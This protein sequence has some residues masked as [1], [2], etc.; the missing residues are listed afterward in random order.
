MFKGY[1]YRHWI[2]NEEGIEKSY[3]GLTRERPNRRWRNGD[4]YLK[5]GQ[6]NSKFGNAIR[7]YGWDSFKHEIIGVVESDTKEQLVL[8]LNEWEIYYIEK[9]DSF[10]NGYNSTLGGKSIVFS[11]EVRKKIS[12]SQKGK[13]MSEE[14]KKKMSNAKKGKQLNNEHKKKIGDTMRGRK[15]SEESKKKI[16]NGQRTTKVICIT[17]GEV[18]DS[19]GQASRHY[20]VDTSTIIKCCKGERKTSGKHPTTGERLQWSYDKQ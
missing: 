6:D 1:I 15:H 4:G 3:I 9:Y 2:I 5:K 12:E 17:T 14:S 7:K 16:R 18:F 13:T 20:N 10:Y 11:D 8:D 19:I